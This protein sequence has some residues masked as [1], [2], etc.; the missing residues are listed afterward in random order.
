[1]HS[2][3]KQINVRPSNIESMTAICCVCVCLCARMIWACEHDCACA[4][5]H[6]HQIRHNFGRIPCLLSIF[7]CWEP[8]CS[9]FGSIVWNAIVQNGTEK[10]TTSTRRH[11]LLHFSVY[12]KNKRN[13][14]KNHNDV[15][16]QIDRSIP[17]FYIYYMQS[18]NFIWPEIYRL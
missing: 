8:E 9:L 6:T 7:T 10:C 18:I 12:N 16:N 1:M 3:P 15:D 14:T 13:L 4:K 17:L 5:V 11:M 2:V